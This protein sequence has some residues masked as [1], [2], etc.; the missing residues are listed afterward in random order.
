[1]RYNEVVTEIYRLIG[2]I[3]LFALAG[4][5]LGQLHLGITIGILL[6][7][8]YHLYNLHLLLNWL[9]YFR[10]QD[11]PDASGLWGRIYDRL[12]REKRRKSR[13]KQY[14]KSIISRME[15]TTD[16][17]SE[18]VILLNQNNEIKWCNK[19]STRLLGIG[20]DDADNNIIH[21]IRNPLLTRYLESGDSPEPLTLPSPP[22]A[23]MH[24][25]FQLTRFGKGEGILVVRDITRIYRLEQMRKDFVANVSH[26]LRTPLTVIRGYLETLG[27]SMD[28]ALASS[29]LWQ[30]ALLQMQQQSERMTN[31]VNDL[32]M[33]SK[34]ETD[35]IEKN[36]HKV[37]LAPLFDMICDEARTIG[38]QKEPLIHCHLDKKLAIIGNDRELY[39]AFS[40]LVNN[41]VQYSEPGKTITL[42]ADQS[43]DGELIIAIKDQGIG[44]EQQH[45][46]RLTERFY[47][48]DPSR[49]IASG[50]TGLGLAIVKHI[51]L[52][53]D[54]H[55][56]IDST[57][58]KG[59]VFSCVFPPQ[60]VGF[61]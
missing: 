16:A 42:K 36:Q 29:T 32:T 40:N 48:V 49:S 9:Q 61:L 60:R 37:S 43:T 58:G 34:L 18:G 35:T 39:S 14:L 19:A 50:G 11:I 57:P 24:L 17:L 15:A 33:L 59:S 45:I 22:P 52:R 1:M 13:E 21:F 12:S 5:L 7:L 46:D 55:L 10:S 41:A 3:T 56:K 6:F 20:T 2:V 53:H 4:L 28:P 23:D 31:L 25:E 38:S 47:R 44:I 51:L 26:E 8:A 54:A 30:K 27:D